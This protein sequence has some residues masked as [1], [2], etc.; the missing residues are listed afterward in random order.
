MGWAASPSKPTRPLCQLSSS[1]RPYRP[2]C[3]TLSPKSKTQLNAPTLVIMVLV[4][5]SSPAPKS[6]LLTGDVHLN[7][8]AA[9]SSIALPSPPSLSIDS[10]ASTTILTSQVTIQ[11]G[12]TG[13]SIWEASYT[14]ASFLI[15]NPGRQSLQLEIS[16]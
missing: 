11:S 14:L 9:A 8:S 3:V 6:H 15:A 5:T 16:S 1:G 7:S 10:Y 2:Y 13:L 12:T 4:R